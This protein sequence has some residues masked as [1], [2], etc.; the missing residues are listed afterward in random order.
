MSVKTTRWGT[1]VVKGRVCV[2]GLSTTRKLIAICVGLVAIGFSN[3]SI[4]QQVIRVS[5][6]AWV[7]LAPFE[8][9][10]VQQSYVVSLQEPTSFGIIIDNQG[11]ESKAGTTAGAELGGAIGNA[12]YIDNALKSG[13]YSA[14]SQLASGILGAVLGS[15]LDR[16]PVSQFH[17][18]YAVKL[19]SGDIQYFDQVKGDAFRH[20]VGVCHRAEPDAH[21]SSTLYA[22]NGHVENHLNP[23]ALVANDN[24]PSVS[25]QP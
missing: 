18:R 14:K 22:N 21:R 9:G 23:N 8:R 6:S 15:T 12:A 19:G 1:L 25:K 20:P 10:L 2:V 11:I 4:A 17:F 3:V 5:Q 7:G 16:N 13:N 24:V